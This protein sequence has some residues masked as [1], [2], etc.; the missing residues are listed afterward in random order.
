MELLI[1]QPHFEEW[2]GLT[3]IVICDIPFRVL[4]VKKTLKHSCVTT[5]EKC[6]QNHLIMS[7]LACILEWIIVFS[8]ESNYKE[9][10]QLRL[11]QSR[12]P[13]V[14][15]RFLKWIETNVRLIGSGVGGNAYLA[16]ILQ[17]LPVV[18]KKAKQGTI[19]DLIH[20]AAIT[21]LVLNSL[22]LQTSGFMYG[23]AMY[24]E[25]LHSTNTFCFITERLGVSLIRYLQNYAGRPYSI[26]HG[27][28][29]ISFWMQILVNL[30]IA[31]T[32]SLFTHFD[33]HGE[34][35]LLRPTTQKLASLHVHQYTWD[36][37]DV[38]FEPVII[39]FGHS[40]VHFHGKT[41]GMGQFPQYGMYTF[42]IP[43]ADMFKLLAYLYGNLRDL[44]GR[45][46][47][48]RT[49]TNVDVWIQ[50]MDILWFQFYPA[51]IVRTLP[52]FDSRKNWR[53]DWFYNGTSTPLA[54]FTPLDM[55]LFIEKHAKEISSILEISK[56]P[57][58]F[59]PRQE[60]ID[61][62][63]TIISPTLLTAVRECFRMEF[64][65]KTPSWSPT[66]E[67]LQTH[68]LP[69]PFTSIP[70]SE[71][72]N[73]SKFLD[74]F[75]HE[76]QWLP[77]LVYPPTKDAVNTMQSFL[78]S[79]EWPRFLANVD[80]AYRDPLHPKKFPWFAQYGPAYL[81]MARWYVTIKGYLEFAK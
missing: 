23:Y 76:R 40:T 64:C 17:R 77:L 38:Q 45:L 9:G 6:F 81:R 11:L 42:P 54:V 47:K 10:K 1:K 74:K 22:R 35:V 21:R 60:W 39:D 62:R 46:S 2:K 63:R 59:S 56:L 19:T 33:L 43:G 68:L 29:F 34:N 71:K 53:N 24:R 4:R 75:Y 79:K 13:S 25:R 16:D 26:H 30:E 73:E 32:R 5:I 12:L 15:P 66:H 72:M 48:K 20:E 65:S 70:F 69:Y 36:F 78:H 44:Q 7:Q 18:I 27:R 57:W 67:E 51:Q 80:A 41:F 14:P 3:P 55:I 28:Q 37:D 58:T 8:N 52:L 49:K 50:I 61:S 31:Q